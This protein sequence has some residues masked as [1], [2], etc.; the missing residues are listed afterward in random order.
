MD[1][2][3][4]SQ[5]L[6]HEHTTLLDF[7]WSPGWTGDYC[8]LFDVVSFSGWTLLV[9][10]YNKYSVSG[11]QTEQCHRIPNLE[12]VYPLKIDKQCVCCV[13]VV[14]NW[15]LI[16]KLLHCCPFSLQDSDQAALM[17]SLLQDT[18][19]TEPAG[20]AE[21]LQQ[22]PISTKFW[23]MPQK[24]ELLPRQGNLSNSPLIRAIE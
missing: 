2:R 24:L 7:V 10:Y 14:R 6:A 18:F 15:A 16:K 17:L 5:F 4:L 20:N 9:M 19:Q 11:W 1:Q 12:F 3:Q 21:N 13:F 8:R 22:Q 23:L